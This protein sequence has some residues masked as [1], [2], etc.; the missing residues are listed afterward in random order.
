MLVKKIQ[1]TPKQYMPLSLVAFQDLKKPWLWTQDLNE[2][3]CISD[4]ETYSE[5]LFHS[6]CSYM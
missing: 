3:I 5:N 1:E 2:L 6:I 4:L